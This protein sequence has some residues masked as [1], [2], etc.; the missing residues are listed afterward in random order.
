MQLQA[1]YYSIFMVIAESSPNRD[2]TSSQNRTSRRSGKLLSSDATR[3]FTPRTRPITVSV[4]NCCGTWQCYVL[5]GKWPLLNIDCI[6]SSI[7]V[8]YNIYIYTY[9]TD[10]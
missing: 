2:K 3:K 1:V 8:N 9:I 6:V 4:C 7:I 10:D 5:H